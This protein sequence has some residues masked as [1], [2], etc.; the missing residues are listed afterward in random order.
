MD[1]SQ[2]LTIVLAV[3]GFAV[4]GLGGL[5]A[6]AIFIILQHLPNISPP[7]PTGQATLAWSLTV[8]ALMV[9]AFGAVT[10]PQ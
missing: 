2:I 8:S 10:R 4:A 6:A 5:A 9:W 1:T 7:S 3:I